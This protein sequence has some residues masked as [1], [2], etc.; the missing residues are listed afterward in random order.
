MGKSKEDI[1]FRYCRICRMVSPTFKFFDDET[2]TDKTFCKI[3]FYEVGTKD[4]DEE[5]AQLNLT[6]GYMNE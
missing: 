5:I 4:S 3:C 1:S 6:A 2:Q